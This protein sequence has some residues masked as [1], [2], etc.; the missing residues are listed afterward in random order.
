VNRL[1]AALMERLLPRRAA[2][3]V[4]ATNTRDLS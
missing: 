3:A 1:A 2:V 4:M